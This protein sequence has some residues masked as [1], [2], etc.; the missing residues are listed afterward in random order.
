MPMIEAKVSVK[1]TD[2]KRDALK[3]EFGKALSVLGKSESY[4]M[5]SLADSQDLYFGGKKLDLGAYVEV[6]VFGEV[7]AAATEKMTAEVCK[8]MQDELS[9][10]G[11]AV[12]V[13]YFGTKNWGWN[14]SNF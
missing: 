2:E 14:G 10:P 12:Y 3:T 7:D 6:K 8:I 1:L 4:L 5:V 9:I 11:N 13:S